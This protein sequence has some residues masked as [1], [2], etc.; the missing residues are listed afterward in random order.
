MY[1]SYSPFSEGL[2]D[3]LGES[4]W[5]RVPN[6]FNGDDDRKALRTGLLEENNLKS[7]VII[8]NDGKLKLADQ[9]Q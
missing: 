1:G 2:K 6:T 8:D 7:K 9:A 3:T 5:R 4:T